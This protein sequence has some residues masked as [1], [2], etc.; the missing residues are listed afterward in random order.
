MKT[1]LFG[2]IKISE[3]AGQN[4]CIAM[5]K[6]ISKLLQ[7]LLPRKAQPVIRLGLDSCFSVTNDIV[8]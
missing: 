5:C 1:H 6:T 3:S 4:S 8:I 7:F 2:W